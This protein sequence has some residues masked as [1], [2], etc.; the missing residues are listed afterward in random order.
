MATTRRRTANRTSRRPDAVAG[1]HIPAQPLDLLA[2]LRDMTL[3][4]LFEEEAE[5]QYKR[6][7]I[8]GYCHLAIGQEAATVG[9]RRRP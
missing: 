3:I 5:R 1:A 9:R 4:R 7:R 2:A 6:A 8:G